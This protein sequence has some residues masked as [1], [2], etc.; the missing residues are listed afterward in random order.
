MM[1]MMMMMMLMMMQ[2]RTADGDAN[3]CDGS[4]TN[5]SSKPC[6]L[7]SVDAGSVE[8]MWQTLQSLLGDDDD[9]GAS[10]GLGRLNFTIAYDFS[11]RSLIVRV[12]EAE[13]L[14][15]KDKNGTSD[16]YVKVQ[17][18]QRIIIIVVNGLHI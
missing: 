1:M 5:D 10:Y 8:A 14:P 2:Q 6:D 17:S 11:K 12:H 4:A 9:T 18:L 15:A 7:E 16:P 13:N 3:R